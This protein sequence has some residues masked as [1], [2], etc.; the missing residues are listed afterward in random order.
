MTRELL[1]KAKTRDLGSQSSFFCGIE[2]AEVQMIYA[3]TKF[4]GL[5]VDADTLVSSAVVGP[6]GCIRQILAACASAQICPATVANVSVNVVHMRRLRRCRAQHSMQKYQLLSP[7][8]P[9]H[10]SGIAVSVSSPAMLRSYFYICDINSENR[11][12]R[13]MDARNRRVLND[14][15]RIRLWHTL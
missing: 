2:Q 7:A 6:D 15:I 3:G 13:T 1:M 12:V 10:R 9:D 14:H 5:L 4:T 8:N 11:P